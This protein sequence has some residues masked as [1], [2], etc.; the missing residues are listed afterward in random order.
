MSCL[1]FD[2]FCE[3]SSEYY[4]ES[5][6]EEDWFLVDGIYLSPTVFVSECF[7]FQI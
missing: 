2:Q 4:S 5:S 1:Q 6:F 7:F 3:E